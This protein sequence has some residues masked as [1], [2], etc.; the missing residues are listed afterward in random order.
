MRQPANGRTPSPIAG[1]LLPRHTAR[2]SASGPRAP[3]T[4]ALQRLADAVAPGSRPDNVRRLRGGIDAATHA[5]DLVQANGE[6]LRVVVRR[7]VP[8]PGASTE[9]RARFALRFWQ[10]LK[11]VEQMQ[12][13]APRPVW[14]DADG[15]VFGAPTVVMSYVPGGVVNITRATED[16]TLQL[17]TALLAI[18]RAPLDGLDTSFL[19]SPELLDSVFERAERDPAKFAGHPD[20]TAVLAALRR[21]RPRLHVQ[22]PA[23]AHGDYH[24][25]NTLWRRGRLQAVVDWDDARLQSP[26]ED[27]AYCHFDLSLFPAG[28]VPG[29]FLRHYEAAAGRRIEQRFFWDLLVA[30]RPMPDPVIW[31]PGYHDAGFTEVTPDLL[32]TRLRAFIA[33]ALRRAQEAEAESA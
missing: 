12:L 3:S 21:W 33:D 24:F 2:V 14:F 29:Q 10:T 23:L 26:A 28:D 15:A 27:V 22:P 8:V 16:R 5:V 18:H 17:A 11:L 7:Y 32:R 13:P 20:G 4:A 1:S 25:G 31:L 30:T 9:Q 6:R 19:P